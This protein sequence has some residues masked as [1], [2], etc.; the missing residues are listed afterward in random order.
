MLLHAVRAPARLGGIVDA[1]RDGRCR[2]PDVGGCRARI[3]R[4]PDLANFFRQMGR[5]HRQGPRHRRPDPHGSDFEHEHQ[6]QTR[7]PESFR[8]SR[9]PAP[10]ARPSS[11]SNGISRPRAPG[12]SGPNTASTACP[13]GRSRCAMST[14]RTKR[15]QARRPS[16]NSSPTRRNRT[17]CS[18]VSPRTATALLPPSFGPG[19]AP[20]WSRRS[21]PPAL[22]SGRSPS[23]L[24]FP[25]VLRITPAV[26]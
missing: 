22:A 24:A 11:Y 7:Q 15:R 20:I 14:T 19:P 13:A 4:R 6:R 9:S 12:T 1:N 2:T 21:P 25:P 26:P 10:A 16:A 18:F 8:A 5:H 23:R 3:R 17:A